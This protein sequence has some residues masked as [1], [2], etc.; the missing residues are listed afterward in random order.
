MIEFV[1]AM[2]NISGWG[3]FAF[4]IICVVISLSIK[5]ALSGTLGIIGATLIRKSKRD[6]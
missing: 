3:L 6:N 4:L 1:E 5:E 2:N